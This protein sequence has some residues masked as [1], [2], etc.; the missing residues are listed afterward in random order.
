VLLRDWDPIGVQDEPAAQDEYDSYIGGVY[1]LLVSGA[2]EQQLA[3]HLWRIEK[4]TIGLPALNSAELLPVARKLR[5]LDV[6]M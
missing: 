3:D 6:K 4:D 1:H 5:A 2:T